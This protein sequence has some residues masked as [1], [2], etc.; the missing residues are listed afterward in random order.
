MTTPNPLAIE[1]ADALAPAF[2]VTTTE[3]G[4]IEVRVSG[5]WAL[6]DKLDFV[7]AVILDDHHVRLIHL[8]HNEICKGEASFSGS[9]LAYLPALVR[10][11]C[12]AE[13]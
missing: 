2:H 8:T 3:Q 7:R 6:S 12:E 9:M 1:L 10:E 5:A 4:W 11:F 13:F